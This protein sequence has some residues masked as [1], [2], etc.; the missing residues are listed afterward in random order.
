MRWLKIY[1]VYKINYFRSN[2]L[3]FKEKNLLFISLYFSILVDLFRRISSIR[4][5]EKSTK[6]HLCKKVE[7]HCTVP[8]YLKIILYVIFCDQFAYL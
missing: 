4:D 3:C 6:A 2:T 1:T 5:A 7:K 8:V